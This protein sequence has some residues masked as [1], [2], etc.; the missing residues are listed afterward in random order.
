LIGDEAFPDQGKSRDE[1]LTSPKREL[2][3]VKREELAFNDVAR[4]ALSDIEK[5]HGP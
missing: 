1:E 4:N 2:A 5:R 3:K